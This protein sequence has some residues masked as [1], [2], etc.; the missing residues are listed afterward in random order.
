MQR[1]T[2]LLVIHGIGEQRCGQTRDDVI[3]A[4]RL[5]Y[6]SA[7]AS[8]QRGVGIVATEDWQ[9][10]LY[11]VYWANILSGPAVAGSFDIAGVQQLVWFPWL[12]HRRIPWYK[13][14]YPYGLVLT[15]TAFLV[16][17]GLVLSAAY[18]G[19]TLLFA[20]FAGVSQ[21]F[22]K[23]GREKRKRLGP[24]EAAKA[25]AAK[26]AAVHYLLDRFAADVLNYANAA[27]GARA[28]VPDAE[29]RIYTRLDKLLQRAV[30]DGCPEIQVLAHSL[31]SLI[32]Y[33]AL[34]QRLDRLSS[35]I[36]LPFEGAAIGKPRLTGFLTIGSPLEKIQ[37]FWPKLLRTGPRLGRVSEEFRWDNFK[38]PLDPVGGVLTR[39]DEFASVIA[40]H[41]V[42]GAGGLMSA[43]SGY[44]R[45]P[46][47][48]R[49]FGPK[50]TGKPLEYSPAGTHKFWLYLRIAF[51]TLGF[52]VLLVLLAVL[53]VVFIMAVGSIG[54]LVLALPAEWLGNALS[55]KGPVAFAEGF[56][57][58]VTWMF[59]LVLLVLA[60]PL[61]FAAASKMHNAHW[62]W[63]EAPEAN[64]GAEPAVPEKPA[65]KRSTAMPET[66]AVA[67]SPGTKWHLLGSVA[68]LVAIASVGLHV[69]QRAWA[70]TGILILMT[71]FAVL[72]GHG[73]TGAPWGILIDSRNK[74]SLSRLQMLLWTLVI[75]SAL[76]TAILGNVP[77]TDSPMEI[78][79]PVELWVLL[80][81]SGATAVGAPA[82]LSTKRGK[83]ADPNEL[84]KT[85]K[86]LGE[87]G[88]APL[89]TEEKSVVLRNKDI[90]DA[91]FSELLK[92]DESGN[93]ATVDLGKLQMFF[94]TFVL[95]CGYGAAMY[96]L[97]QKGGLVTSLPPV[98]EGMNVLLGISQTGYLATKAVSTSK[99]A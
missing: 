4:L 58:V 93:A 25:G 32:A 55:W 94:F 63:P 15:W 73:I 44:L 14:R 21:E 1:C 91:R 85:E 66:K 33:R 16:P 27:A 79:I 83:Q 12:N 39:Y 17:F 70:W 72:N 31:G 56:R 7:K 50:L 41:P 19:A 53:G 65:V 29:E 40:N 48:L 49:E 45:N 84:Q 69:P 81:L 28:P 43:H 98:Q 20:L 37:F 96:V 95:V 57:Q 59:P 3:A 9:V 88:A 89:D 64:D 10:R 74:M 51:E 6:P 71:V 82:L 23:T 92:G 97:F 60:V 54:G 18:Y 8:I 80:G 26:S 61:G 78:V 76:I 86:A 67:K 34:T 42:Q 47:F 68:I 11:E 24:L 36:A 5:A 99:E 35:M 22:T 2:G 52:P 62:Q 13:N 38:S 75:L 46:A 30:A 90:R 87:Q 77:L